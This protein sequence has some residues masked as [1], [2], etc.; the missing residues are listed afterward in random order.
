MNVFCPQCGAKIPAE[1]LNAA[2]MVAK[3][4]PCDSL[5]SLVGLVDGG[6]LRR[7]PAINKDVPQ[8]KGIRVSESDLDLRIIKPWFSVACIPLLVL[9]AIW[10][11][12]VCSA[13][14]AA[15]TQD[16]APKAFLI[17]LVQLV[18]GAIVTFFT[19]QYLV[20][21][22]M[23]V[24]NASGLIVVDRPLTLRRR[25]RLAVDSIDQIYC[26]S[27]GPMSK[28]RSSGPRRFEVVA[29]DTEGKR[30]RL[31]DGLIEIDHARFI[32]RRLESYL[33]IPDRWVSGEYLGAC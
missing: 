28:E 30:H 20:N 14:Y 29:I 1:G 18:L 16:F 23:I 15:V 5:F 33:G 25:I 19:L 17:P 6:G 10:D 11:Y 2:S 24:A 21:R 32:E 7:D 4:D 31:V 26:T 3:C 27:E 12:G 22:T 8:P 9:C 13:Y